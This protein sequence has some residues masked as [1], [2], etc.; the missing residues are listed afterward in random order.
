MTS[1]LAF[2]QEAMIL[3]ARFLILIVQS[4]LQVI[5]E[6]QQPGIMR[7]IFFQGLQVAVD[8]TDGIVDLMRYPGG[9]LAD[10]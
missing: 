2:A 7:Q 1:C 8:K 9:K 5:K 6:F 3:E 10:S 4:F